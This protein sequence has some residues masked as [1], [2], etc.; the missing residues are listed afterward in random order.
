MSKVRPCDSAPFAP[1][2]PPQPGRRHTH[3]TLPAL[4]PAFDHL[5]AVQSSSR[6]PWHQ[7]YVCAS[8]QQPYKYSLF[9]LEDGRATALAA[10]SPIT[11]A[12]AVIYGC[13]VPDAER[14]QVDDDG[15]WVPVL[16]CYLWRCWCDARLL[17]GHARLRA[18]SFVET[19][20]HYFIGSH[21]ILTV[22]KSSCGSTF[23]SQRQSCSLRGRPGVALPAGTSPLYVFASVFTEGPP[24]PRDVVGVTSLII[25]SI[26]ALV[27]LKYCTIVL[28]ADDHGQGG[29]PLRAVASSC[30][31]P[32]PQPTR[33]PTHRCLPLR[34]SVTPVNTGSHVVICP[35][36][37][38]PMAL[39]CLATAV[40]RLGS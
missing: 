24:S 37:S 38:V 2:P 17:P 25:W 21:A 33:I 7:P 18:L 30:A 39:I 32:Y 16:G 6:E 23:L 11:P 1:T 27:L 4:G 15:A 19:S 35:A 9:C 36:L 26:T 31:P 22:L 14:I 34:D 8:C 3:N 20:P 5:S 13:L 28:R 12:R 10:A 29:F 40:Q